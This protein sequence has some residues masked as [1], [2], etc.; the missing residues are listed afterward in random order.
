MIQKLTTSLALAGL[1][2]MTIFTAQADQTIEIVQ[3]RPDIVHVDIGADGGP[4]GDL[5]AFEAPFQTSEG[6]AG[7]ISGMVMTVDLDVGTG[8]VYHDRVANIVLDFGA[9]DTLVVGGQ[10][11]YGAQEA[12]LS[13]DVPQLRAIVGGT[14]RFIGARGQILTTRKDQGHYQHVITLLD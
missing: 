5:L 7:I 6:E 4:H 11:R 12:E 13:A 8:G 3:D 9:D 1:G 2:L 14:G 10:S